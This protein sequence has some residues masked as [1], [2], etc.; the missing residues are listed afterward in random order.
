MSHLKLDLSN[1][2]R[3][4]IALISTLLALV[5]ALLI[6]PQVPDVRYI[7]F[8]LAVIFNAWYGGF[9]S[10]LLCAAL[11]IFSIEFFMIEPQFVFKFEPANLP[12]LIRFGIVTSAISFVEERRLRSQIALRDSRNQLQVVLQGLAD[13]VTA[14]DSTG[15]LIFANEAAARMTGYDSVKEFLSAPPQHIQQRFELFAESGAPLTFADLPGRQALAHGISGQLISRVHYLDTDAERWSII[16]STPVL[17]DKGQVQMAI[18]IFR[19]ITDLKN[20]QLELQNQQAYL[21]TILATIISAVITT[22]KE[23]KVEFM[24]PA[25]ERLTGWDKTRAPGKPVSDIFRIVSEGTRR[26]IENPVESL[27][28]EE[29][30]TDKVDP[31]LLIQ[32]DGNELPIEYTVTMLKDQNNQVTGVVLVFRDISQQRHAEQE[33]LQLTLLVEAERR[34]LRNILENVPG[35][36]WEGTLIGADQKLNFVNSYAE[37]MLGYTVEEWMTI[38]NLGASITHPDDLEL[39]REQARTLYEAGNLNMSLQFRAISKDEREVPMEVRMTVMVDDAGNPTG[40]YGLMTD[41]SQQKK[42]E[43]ALQQYALDLKSSN[44]QLERFAYIASHDLQEPLRMISSYLQLLEQRYGDIFDADAKEFIGFAVDGAIRM[45]ALI[46][47]LLIYSRV[48]TTERN[49][50]S[51]DSAGALRQALNNLKVKIEDSQAKISYDSLPTI[52]G[53]QSLFIQLFQNLIS[54]G[55][56]FQNDHPPQIYIKCSRDKDKWLFSVRDN[57]IGIEPQYLEAIFTMF[58]RLHTREQYP[59]TGIGLAICKKVVEHHRGRIW[60]ESQ[61]GVGTTF[62]FT[63]PR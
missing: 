9:T 62:Y 59:G 18:N 35:M 43:A 3:Y 48:K 40:T 28:R 24:N 41:V 38:P 46:N 63:I 37:K 17:D 34:R 13:G 61:V 25:A 23:G 10:G 47:D 14:Q 19:D 52:V 22:D 32:H 30:V 39:V 8:T 42:A 36:V 21:L 12:Q 7:F 31:V 60:A 49:F 29:A 27:L 53:N 56:K 2:S 44:E 50:A 55:L 58:K 26:T 57:G 15:K 33:R 4:G 6:F 11:S 45:K 54:N 5:L 1:F 51:F 20:A 16:Q